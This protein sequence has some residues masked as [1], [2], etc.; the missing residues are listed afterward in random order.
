M[1]HEFDQCFSFD[2]Q[3]PKQPAQA[4]VE[5]SVQDKQGDIHNDA[6]DSGVFNDIM[7]LERPCILQKAPAEDRGYRYGPAIQLAP[8]QF[9]KRPIKP[10]P[11]TQDDLPQ[12]LRN[13]LSPLSSQV[14]DSAGSSFPCS[15]RAH[16][17]KAVPSTFP[18]NESPDRARDQPRETPYRNSDGAKIS[19]SAVA[20]TGQTQDA[21][22]KPPFPNS[23]PVEAARSCHRSPVVENTVQFP[24]V[25]CG[26]QPKTQ[27][28]AAGPT[29]ADTPMPGQG[30]PL[31]EHGGH[32]GHLPVLRHQLPK[33]ALQAQPRNIEHKEGDSDRHHDHKLPG[34]DYRP[35]MAGSAARVRSQ[36]VNRLLKETAPIKSTMPTARTR[37]GSRGSNV[38]KQRSKNGSL[39]S[40]PLLRQRRTD[41]SHEFTTELAGI[42]NEFTQQQ[43]SA[44]EE[45]RAR[46]HKI[47]KS[48]KHD[49]SDGSRVIAQQI[50][51]LN[52]QDK[53]IKNLQES[54]EQLEAQMKDIEAKLG[55]S[56]DRAGRLEEKYHICKAHLNSAIQ[57]QQDLYKR[58]KK[59]WEEAIDQVRA[60]KE[61]QTSEGDMAV[62]KAEV[63][64][65]Q[66]MEKVR[67]I[68]AQ[69]KSEAMDLYGKIGALTQE[70][71]EKDTQLNQEKQSVYA[72]S[73]KV[74]DLETTFAGFEG[75]A[76]QSKEILNKLEEQHKV[77]DD[78]HQRVGQ[79]FRNRLDAI[80][81]RLEALS[82]MASGQPNALAELRK[83]QTES[84]NS[85]TSKLDSMLDS[86]DSAK[87]A[88]RQLSADLESQM[89]QIW[90][91]LDNQFVSLGQRLEEKGE[92][93]GMISAL[94]RKK[95]ADCREHESQLAVLRET[96]EKQAEQLR[97]LERN[98][99]AMD[100]AH[101]EDEE[102][103]RRLE[104][105]ATEVDRLRGHLMSRDATVFELQSQLD[106]KNREYSADL[107][108]CSS[109]ILELSRLLEE[110]DQ[111]CRVAAHQAAETARRESR[112]EMES[113]IAETESLLRETQAERDS[114]LREVKA[115][116]QRI[117]HKE[118]DE[119][120]H[121]AT[122]SSLQKDL[123]AAEAR[124][125]AASKEL[126]QH[127]ISLTQLETR[128][129]SQIKALETELEQSRKQAT[130]LELDSQHR[131]AKFQ[132]LIAGLKHRAAQNGLDVG[133][134]DRLS[135]DKTSVEDVRA[136][137]VRALEHL[138]LS[139][140]SQATALGEPVQNFLPAGEDSKFCSDDN[141]H[142]VRAVPDNV[143]GFDQFGKNRAGKSAEFTYTQ[144]NKMDSSSGERLPGLHLSKPRQSR[145]VMVRSPANVPNQPVPPSVDQEKMRRR[146]G[147]QPKSIMKR[148]TRSTSGTVQE[149]FTDASEE[150]GGVF[151]RS[152]QDA[153]LA[154]R[155]VSREPALEFPGIE[156]AQVPNGL[157]SEKAT[158]PGL[159]SK[160]KR[161]ETSRSESSTKQ[162]RSSKQTKKTES[163]ILSSTA[164]ME[165]TPTSH[166]GGPS[167]RQQQLVAAVRHQE[168]LTVEASDTKSAATRSSRKSSGLPSQGLARTRSVNSGPV[169][170][171]RQ[172]NLR[173]YGSQKTGGS[174]GTGSH[175]KLQFPLRSQS[176]SESQSQSQS[177]FWPK[178]NE[179]SHES[180]VFSQNGVNVEDGLLLSFPSL[181][182]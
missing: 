55:A 107:K 49:L 151:K 48:L 88:T 60:M 68:V 144:E 9:T 147:S 24:T 178:S 36:P 32:N 22:G 154:D 133:D 155:S 121:A 180:T 104:A 109:R 171:S 65:E 50:A 52:A 162:S 87:E 125:K 145:R 159:G 126:E 98:L 101:E 174:S 177:R 117:Q 86:G 27:H 175:V 33:H 127:S 90:E 112:K 29:N 143:S 66:M 85:V 23:P 72:L 116:K 131:H 16:S 63:I 53:Q 123:A 11:L 153:D 181:T 42:I 43:S 84:W 38:S 3:E 172:H 1:P 111:S 163:P 136:G 114:L 58:S 7:L 59:Q 176:Q 128:L 70:L 13:K 30:H 120:Q 20:G 106:A 69:H 118:K 41:I 99:V 71:Q 134:F 44:L 93:N 108:T 179:E 94:Y 64:R 39:A 164:Q 182:A 76:A 95:E 31:P 78:Q 80:A 96:T 142:R 113:G 62:R 165:E 56:E 14:D 75:L 5:E 2:Q 102:T 160:R 124:G 161:S 122:I 47:I 34:G 119:C 81:D 91:R 6:V 132:A 130:E 28:P 173:T 169:L 167:T 26:G 12:P 17:G 37:P 74:K 100:A 73:E 57:E 168:A 158:G 146:E 89:K 97:E 135:D 25:P 138:A 54:K 92:E 105:S 51:K 129:T 115:L 45:Q 10:A 61:A 21:R 40:S 19:Q 170:G 15:G 166:P 157:P 137:I 149:N 139:Q 110:K 67:H 4:A 103:I 82:K 46:Y 35:S 150:R 156:A 148:V 152:S 83:A 141:I 8:D 18:V 140:K 79:E 77:S